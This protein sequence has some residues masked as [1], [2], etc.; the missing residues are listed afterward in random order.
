M[1][2][3]TMAFVSLLFALPTFGGCGPDETETFATG[4]DAVIGRKRRGLEHRRF[5]PSSGVPLPNVGRGAL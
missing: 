1:L 4:E 3:K 2:K 5:R